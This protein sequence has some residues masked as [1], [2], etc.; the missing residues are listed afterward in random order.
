MLTRSG[1]SLRERTRTPS[2]LRKQSRQS[3]LPFLLAVAAEELVEADPLGPS[4]G[5]LLFRRRATITG[6]IAKKHRSAVFSDV[7]LEP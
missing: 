1:G 2:K 7:E 3:S 4:D 5:V 6:V